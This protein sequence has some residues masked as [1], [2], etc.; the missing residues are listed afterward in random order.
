MNFFAVVDNIG[1][2]LGAV[3]LLSFVVVTVIVIAYGK[4]KEAQKRAESAGISSDVLKKNKKDLSDRLKNYKDSKHSSQHD[5]KESVQTYGEDEDDS[6]KE[7]QP[8]IS[9][10]DFDEEDRSELV[11]AMVLGEILA[12]PKCK[13]LYRKK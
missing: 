1:G 11:K 8:L 6:V 13:T 9:L 2:I 5:F 4:Q 3:V 7:G 10:A 12:Q